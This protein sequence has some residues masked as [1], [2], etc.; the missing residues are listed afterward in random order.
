VLSGQLFGPGGDTTPEYWI[1]GRRMRAAWRRHRGRPCRSRAPSVDPSFF[2]FTALKPIYGA[3]R[4]RTPKIFGMKGRNEH[5]DIIDTAT[6]TALHN[7]VQAHLR[8]GIGRMIAMLRGQSDM[9]IRT[10]MPTTPSKAPGAPRVPALN[11]SEERRGNCYCS[12]FPRGSGPCL[13][14]YWRR[15]RLAEASRRRSQVHEAS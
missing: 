8:T 10:T 14:C 9:N 15:L 12:A 5:S 6:R 7:L 13:P 1:D 2:V 4:S 3:D 11:Q